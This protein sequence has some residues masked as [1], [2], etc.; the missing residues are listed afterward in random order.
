MKGEGCGMLLWVFVTE[1]GRAFA[2]FR[3]RLLLFTALGFPTRLYADESSFEGGFSFTLSF[4][5]ELL[6]VAVIMV[7]PTVVCF[8]ERRLSDPSADRHTARLK[9]YARRSWMGLA[10][11]PLGTACQRLRFSS[12]LSARAFNLVTRVTSNSFAIR[13]RGCLRIR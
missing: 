8:G 11:S 4:Y 6:R 5:G 9:M 12:N 7:I 13:D 1:L 3:L 10:Y 2:R